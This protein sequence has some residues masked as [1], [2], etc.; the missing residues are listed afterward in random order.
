MILSGFFLGLIAAASLA[1]ALFFLKFW[2]ESHDALFLA[3]AA[4][5][6]VEAFSRVVSL[7]QEHPNE[8][9]PWVYLVRL[10]SALWIIAAILRK[11]S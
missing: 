1:A 5:F 9:S 11:N 7:V 6:V 4:F 8:A 10:A 2:R 3:F